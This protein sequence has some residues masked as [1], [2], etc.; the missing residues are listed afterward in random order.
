MVLLIVIDGDFRAV[1]EMASR[2][3][4]GWPLV[5]SSLKSFLETGETLNLYLGR[6]E[7]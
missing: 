2:V 7:A 4:Y 5:L 1:S 6:T 3:P